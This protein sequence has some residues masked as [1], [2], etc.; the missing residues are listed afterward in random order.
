MPNLAIIGD[1]H[2]QFT[3][4]DIRYFND[5]EYDLILFTGDLAEFDP[6]EDLEVAER[7]SKLTK[8]A[9]FIP[10][11]HDI[12]NYF[13]VVAEALQWRWLEWLSS[14]GRPRNVAKLIQALDPVT[15]CGYS[16]HSFMADGVGDGLDFDVIAARPFSMGGN[17]INFPRLIAKLH[18]VTS[19]ESSIQK[20][21]AC[22]D[23]AQS[24][25]LIFLAHSGP[26][27]CGDQPTDLW[28]KD[29]GNTQ[30]DHGEPDLA[31]AIAYARTQG[32]RIIAVVAGHMH[33]LTKQGEQRSWC[34]I[35]DGTC[36]INA[37]RVPRIFARDGQQVR[38][39]IRLVINKNEAHYEEKLIA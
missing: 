9:L 25:N 28:G 26:T 10:G 34:L 15:C 33:H 17:R 29:F 14:F 8:P 11:N 2:L 22:V 30:G 5:S 1:I 24:N 4:A 3:E 19:I 18:N 23:Q 16:V 13:N 27:G 32:K 20:L 6:K 12:A 21:K 31:A 38:H 7:L 37:A 39:H 35:Q 36:Y